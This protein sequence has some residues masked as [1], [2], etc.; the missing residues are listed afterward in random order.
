MPSATVSRERDADRS[1]LAILDAAEELFAREG[2]AATSLHDIGAAAGLSRGT[3][4]YF[5]GS[6]Q[7]LYD[8]VLDRC[9]ASAREAVRVGRERT[10]GGG[11]PPAHVL[12]GVVA[13]YF[14]F[15]AAH[16][17]FVRLVEWEA[18]TGGR[19][20]ASLPPHVEAL[21]EAL[22]AIVAEL[23][24]SPAQE[25]QAAHLLLSILALCWFPLVHADTLVRGLQ[26]DPSDPAFFA[27]RKRHVVG[28]VLRGMTAVLSASPEAI[29]VGGSSS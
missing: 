18:L 26:F 24:F 7:S 29:S 2:F 5:F 23:D 13:D 16:P 17:T 11:E 9:Y 27:A 10:I 14:D 19:H 1:R 4:A 15:L 8:A 25:A 3:P 20:L 22:S 12:A 21:R 28:L 6:K